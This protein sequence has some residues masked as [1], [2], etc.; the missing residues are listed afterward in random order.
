[1]LSQPLLFRNCN[2]GCP[3]ILI[4]LPLT[5]PVSCGA[6]M[7]TSLFALQNGANAADSE[8]LPV[9]VVSSHSPWTAD[10]WEAGTPTYSQNLSFGWIHTV[11]PMARIANPPL[12]PS[13]IQPVQPLCVTDMLIE[14]VWPEALPDPW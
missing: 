7:D 3:E 12:R 8:L 10:S 9:P 5:R 4:V 13:P 2:A 1:M 6:S 11:F 14:T